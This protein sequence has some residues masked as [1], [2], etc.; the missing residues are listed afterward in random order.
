MQDW[1]TATQTLQQAEQALDKG[2]WSEAR[3][4]TQS[5]STKIPYWADRGKSLEKQV[6]ARAEVDSK[7][8][9]QAAYDSAHDRDFTAA[10]TTLKQIVPETTTGAIAQTK[11]DEYTAK[12]TVKAQA[13]LQK[14][15]DRA[16]RRDFTQALT[17]LGQIPQGTP[18]SEI[19]Q[20]KVVEYSRKA[21]IR[22]RLMLKAAADHAQQQNF[23]TALTAL[24]KNPSGLLVDEMIDQK[25]TEHTAQLNRQAAQLLQQAN[26]EAATARQSA[27]IA[28]LQKVPIGTPAYSQA[29][30][31]LAAIAQVLAASQRNLNPTV[32]IRAV[33]DLNPGSHLRET[34]PIMALRQNENS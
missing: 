20:K 9:L 27:A 28:F 19:A 25:L 22:A 13:D 10:L 23:L 6:I 4:L 18:A 15:Y 24:E 29:H 14:A 1:T 7:N 11:V 26:V 31:Q 17:Y 8:L 34:T 32:S 2:N 30:E 5:M 21:Q 3:Q 33:Q 12:Q 16:I